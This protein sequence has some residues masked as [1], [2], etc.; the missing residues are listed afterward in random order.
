ME[1]ID[2]GHRSF[3]SARPTPGEWS[4]VPFSS[5]LCR[6]ALVMVIDIRTAML[7][8]PNELRREPLPHVHY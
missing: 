6:S 8:L 1:T 7:H 5:R 3:R 2:K 4:D